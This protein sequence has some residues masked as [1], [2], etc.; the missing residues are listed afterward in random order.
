MATTIG[1]AAAP[2]NP[3]DADTFEKILSAGA[4]ILGVAMVVAIL[5]GHAHWAEVPVLVWLHLLTIGVAV[6][7]TP[8]MLL[9]R[10]GTQRHRWLGR[11]WAVSMAATAALTF[12]IATINSGRYS[13]IHL[14]SAWTLIQV[15]LIWWTAR[16]HQVLRHRRAVRGMVTG[17]LLVAG[18][19]TFP[20]DRMLG[21]WLF[22]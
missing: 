20:F 22:G 12:G 10:R 14:L 15:P 16:T 3:W 5:R 21:T 1:S 6:A 2:T 13:L 19:F 7:L 8:T 9:A 4:V 17:A 18:F 11:I